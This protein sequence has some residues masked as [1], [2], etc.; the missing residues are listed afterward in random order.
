[1]K[2]RYLTYLLIALLLP[3]AASALPDAQIQ[4]YDPTPAQPGDLLSVQVAINNNADTSIRDV[5][6][7]ILESATVRPEGR[8]TLRAGTISAFSS[9]VGTLQVRVAADAPSGEATLRMRVREQGGQWQEQ[10]GII[11]VQSSQAGILISNVQLQPE[12]ISPGRT[13]TAE[14]T[15]QNNANSLL[16]GVSTRLQLED[17]PFVPTTTASRQRVGDLQIGQQETIEYQLTAQPDAQAGIY[18]V[19]ITLS[20][21]DRNGNSIDLHDTIGLS[22]TTEQI[23]TA[24]VDNVQRTNNGA[25]IS[26]RI[27][28]KG[29]SEIKFLEATVQEQEGYSIREQERQTYLGNVASDDWQ[30][31]R[32]EVI[33]GQEQVEIPLSYSFKDSFNQEHQ[34]EQTLIVTLPEPEQSGLG[35]VGIVLVLAVIAGGYWLYKRRRAKK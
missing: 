16:R 30:T 21:L 3:V 15:L 23:T 11:Q 29:L 22:I 19:P 8:N 13:A 6:L 1:M 20:F 28:N 35:V 9:F 4:R 18:R 34:R 31:M 32:F 12:T 14:I 24:N 10:T 17:T 26:V 27:V 2:M 33:S 25:E 5:E 7:E